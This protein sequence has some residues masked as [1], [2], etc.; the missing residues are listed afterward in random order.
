MAEAV[1][2]ELRRAEG[3]GWMSV[4]EV[5]RELAR[6]RMGEDGQLGLRASVLNLVAVT[7][8]ETAPQVAEAVSRLAGEHPS[9]T[10]LL[11]SDPEGP[12]R[13]DVR[14]S[15][16]CTPRGGGTQVCAEQITIHAEGP[17][18]RHLE[19]IAG[20]LL[21][22]DLP[23]FLFYT[24]SFSPGSPEFVPLARLADRLILDSSSWGGCGR[25]FA[26]A[27]GVLSREDLPPA[28]DLQWATL[29]PWRA[30][31]SE[32]FAAPQLAGE[33]AGIGEVE[34]HHAPDGEC[35]ALLLA[36]WL[37]SSL[38]WRL[39]AA[40]GPPPARELRFSGPPGEVRLR[41]QP[42]TPAA[43]LARV[44]LRSADCEFCV[45]RSLEHPEARATVSRGGEV[46]GE[47]VAYIGR[48]D[49]SAMLAEELRCRGRDEAYERALRAAAE[50]VA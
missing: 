15:A 46:V 24:G 12:E 9:R 38:G 41:M 25:A 37:A 47:S 2:G 1:I 28:G 40:S 23:V 22:P 8:E 3:G 32:M 31:I 13:M 17:P 6:L 26:A 39:E 14:L 7:G 43:R 18:A 21:I 33:L 29:T 5:E 45:S 20:P 16:F 27:V 19:S 49:M 10:V 34:I 30:L 11:I 44:I 36:G 4:E 48:F 35:R 42:A 50:V